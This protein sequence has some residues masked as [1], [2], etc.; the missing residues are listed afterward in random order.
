LGSELGRPAAKWAWIGSLACQIPPSTN[1]HNETVSGYNRKESLSDSSLVKHLM[2]RALPHGIGILSPAVDA[3]KINSAKEIEEQ[4]SAS[5][6]QV[7]AG[8]VLADI[9]PG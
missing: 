7:S 9:F 5:V 1:L 6:G 2:F 4:V 3:E 8:Q